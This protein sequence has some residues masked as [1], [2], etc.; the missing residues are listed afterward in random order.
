MY[1]NTKKYEQME[2]KTLKSNTQRNKTKKGDEF[3][4]T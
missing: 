4:N 3:T 1:L 2:I